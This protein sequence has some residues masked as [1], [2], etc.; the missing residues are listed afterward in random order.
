M[1]EKEYLDAMISLHREG[2]RQGPGSD[3]HTQLALSF[4]E[5]RDN[6]GLNVADIGCG[7]GAQTLKLASCLQGHITAIDLF[8]EF[9]EKL[10][11][12]KAERSLRCE[13]TTLAGSM[14]DLP[15]KKESLDIIWSEGAIY[16]IGFARG[17]AYWKGF[18]KA[19]GFMVLSDLTWIKPDR[20]A[21]LEQFWNNEYP[22]A[23]TAAH[24]IKTL[25][26]NGFTVTGYFYLSTSC[27]LDEY[28]LPLEEKLERFSNLH[29]ERDAFLQ[30]VNDTRDEIAFYKKYRH[31]YSYGFY[32]ARKDK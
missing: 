23:D 8:P 12:R 30:M 9:L 22:E 5:N 26:E 11:I 4:V 18:L 6:I 15:F 29:K 13:I 24:K 1:M 14:D 19:G 25:E 28:Y 10:E 27:W 20:P 7:T 21:E 2:Y 32:I 3:H 17:I 31:Y 16:N